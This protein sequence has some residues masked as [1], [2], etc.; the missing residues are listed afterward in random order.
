MDIT[1]PLPKDKNSIESYGPDGFKISEQFYKGAVIVSPT[2]L[3]EVEIDLPQKLSIKDLK[4]VKAHG[5]KREKK[6]KENNLN[7]VQK[8][9]IKKAS[10]FFIKNF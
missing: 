9:K 1:S 5:G 10:N 8:N 2:N 4:K 3:E 7:K 6:L